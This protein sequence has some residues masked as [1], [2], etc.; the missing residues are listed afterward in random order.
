MKTLTLDPP[1]AQWVQDDTESILMKDNK[2]IL[3]NQTPEKID[4]EVTLLGWVDSRRDHGKLAFIDLRDRS[5]VVQVVFLPQINEEAHR[6]ASTL[7][8]EDVVKVLGKVARRSEKNLNT[9]IP[10][11][12][13]EVQGEKIEIINKAEALPLDIYGEGYEIDELVRYRY[14]YLDL[15]RPRIQKNLKLRH[16]IVSAIHEF[17]DGEDFIEIETPYLSKTTPEGARDF[18]VPSRHQPGHFY[19]L[20]QSPQ[21]YKQL[22]MIAGFERYYQVARAFRDED[23]RAD[24]QYEHTQLD[25][26]MSFATRE[27]ILDLVESLVKKLV[28]KMGKKLTFAQFPRLTHK[29]VMEKY[30]SDK[31]DLRSN[32]EDKDEMAFAFV[33]DF[34]L[35]E[36]KDA[37]KRW[38]FSHNPFTSPD[39]KDLDK[40][41]KKVDIASINSLQ[42]DLICNGFEMAS[43]SI[44]ITAP[45]VQKKVFEIMDLTNTEIEADFGH[46]L[47]AYRYGAPNHGGVAIGIDRLTA[48]FANETSIRE[49]VA[50]PV[51]SQGTTSV[52]DAPSPANPKVLKELGLTVDTKEN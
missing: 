9:E 42:Y 28:K 38:T 37:E 35:F 30:K 16:Q 12:Q 4:Q 45:E 21:Q 51:S 2:R 25:I 46:L 33:V 1:L 19:A 13:I 27:E 31:P 22:L 17:L 3:T 44:R 6:T 23:L 26:E 41:T 36:W 10:T 24:R 40:V 18:L 11:G 39:P 47:K 8:S 15:R 48:V 52:M 43:G 34:P 7:S 20:A 49:V 14:R 5:G 29:E 32:P 50:F